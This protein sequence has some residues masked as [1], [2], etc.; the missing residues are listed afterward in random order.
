MVD[1]EKICPRAALIQFIDALAVRSL[2]TFKGVNTTL[3]L[4]VYDLS[5]SYIMSDK[6]G[7]SEV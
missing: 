4:T 6:C 2:I 5:Y 1:F 3:D 7:A